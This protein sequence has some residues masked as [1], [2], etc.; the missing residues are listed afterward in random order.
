MTSMDYDQLA[1]AYAPNRTAHPETLSKLAACC[2]EL[3]AYAILE[4]GCGSGN[5]C[6]ALRRLMGAVCT[7]LDAS[8]RML[9]EASKRAPGVRLVQ[10]RAEQLPFGAD[11]F[12]LIFSVDVI[13]H[14][15]DCA[16]YFR[17]AYRTLRPGGRVCT[18]TESAWMIRNR[19]PLAKY[20]PETVEPETA[21]YPA[22]ESLHRWMEQA[23]L[24]VED[25]DTVERSYEVT[26]LQVFRDKAFS[27][28]HLITEAEFQAGLARMAS[29]LAQGPLAA[30]WRN[31]LLWARK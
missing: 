18:V 4:V 22:V 3:P 20:F 11:R 2:A 6:G 21:R 19:N 25:E 17:E 5:Y 24:R 30:V 23:G 29:D 15:G 10:G 9:A 26:D 31:V 1:K 16:A 14:I 12:D 28:L 8:A 7:G 27:S 13:H